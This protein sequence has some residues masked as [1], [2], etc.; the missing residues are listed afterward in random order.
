MLTVT[1]LTG[2]GG[3][4]EYTTYLSPEGI[5]HVVVLDPAVV[6]G[7][8]ILVAAD[9]AQA[10]ALDAPTQS[11]I[12]TL[13]AAALAQAVALDASTVM[14]TGTSLMD[15][16][17][18]AGL[19]ASTVFCLDAGDSG[20][21]SGSGQTWADLSG[22]GYDFFLGATGSAAS[23]DPTFNGSAGALTN[24]EYWSFDGGDYFRYDAANEATFESWHK[25]NASFT[26]I[27]VLWTPA[28]PGASATLIGDPT[29]GAT[30]PG[31]RWFVQSSN[32]MSVNVRTASANALTTQ[33]TDAALGA[34]AW[35]F[36][37][38]SMRE[39]AAVGFMYL[40]GSYH[41]VGSADA[42]DATY[43]SPSAASAPYKLEIGAAGNATNAMR[44]GQRL[45]AVAALDTFTT[46]AELDD[47]Y[48]E[49]KARWGLA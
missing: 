32:K 26:F 11:V 38:L 40:D 39:A 8:Y 30:G 35:H 6:G 7:G 19:A 29:S 47:I 22:N 20:S 9:M 1:E 33:T 15:A 43:T 42:F 5:L 46:K 2:F 21:Y 25:D 34:D 10:V 45:A 31:V 4:V 24:A 17:T 23:D 12:H 3:S 18:T 14:G 16:I 36:V 41:Q 48:N 27:A 49:I 28:T 44:S 37:A 13:T